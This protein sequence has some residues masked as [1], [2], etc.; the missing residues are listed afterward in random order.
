MNALLEID[1]LTL[2]RGGARL[3]DGVGFALAPDTV[4]VLLGTNGAGKSTLLRC[5]LGLLRPDAG[6]VR[7]IGRDPL[8]ANAAWRGEVGYVPDQADAY[9]W[10]S[11]RDLFR[12]LGAQTPRW[13][14]ERAMELLQRLD[15]P[16][17]RTFAAMSRGEAAKVML[18]AALTPRPRLLVLDEPFERLAP[19]VRDEVLRVFLAEAPVE[20]GAVLLATHDLDVAARAAD[21]VI[22]LDRGHIAADVDVETLLE[23]PAGRGALPRLLRDLYPDSANDEV[24]A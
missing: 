15:A 5:A 8:R 21:R 6:T 2:E 3:L 7:V 19:P 9:P 11:A 12:F 22:V 13:S 1:R 4:T 16:F 24:A 20:G 10:M 18:A 17:E 23:A 14:Q